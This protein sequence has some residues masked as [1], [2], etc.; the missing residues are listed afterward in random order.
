[1]KRPYSLLA[2]SAL[3]VL[4]LSSCNF[5]LRNTSATNQADVILTAA[6]KTVEVQ[7]T[8]GASTPS[9]G[10]ILP[11]A[12]ATLKPG[13]TAHP[14]DP[15]ATAK[16]TGTPDPCDRGDFVE[17]VTVPDG[18]TY[19]PGESFTKTWRLRNTGTCTW[20]TGY[21][22]VFDHDNN[23][24]APASVNFTGDVEPGE[25]ADIS[26]AMTAPQAPGNYRGYWLLRNAQG[27]IFGLG[28]KA[29]EPFYVDIVV[30]RPL[31]AVTGVTISVSPTTWEN[32]CNP[33]ALTIKA[34]I[35]VSDAGEIQSHWKF[36]DGSTSTVFSTNFSKA[37]TKEISYTWEP[38][39]DPGEY[40]GTIS[41]YNDYP[42]HQEFGG[43]SYTL[44]CQ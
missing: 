14:T 24:G 37:G 13:E 34:N 42:N 40:S 18:T 31:F 3:I 26:V 25:T 23:M 12:T 16:V 19:S 5:P 8:Q 41:L 6:A 20:T 21:A 15:P 32:V 33:A 7:L 43:V 22:I 44:K 38:T 27:V 39:K 17:D 1:M 29:K 10:P 36:G 30:A 9:P 4:L 11:T 2:A 28:S 35:T